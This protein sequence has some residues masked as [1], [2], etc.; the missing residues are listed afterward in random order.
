MANAQTTIHAAKMIPA[1]A[2]SP[3]IAISLKATALD[4]REPRPVE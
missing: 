3:F 1:K 2:K 4:N